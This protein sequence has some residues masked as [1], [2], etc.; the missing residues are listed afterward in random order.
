ME[1]VTRLKQLIESGEQVDAETVKYY[2][3]KIDA[4]LSFEF[5]SNVTEDEVDAFFAHSDYYVNLFVDYMMLYQKFLS[6]Q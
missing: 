5:V 6:N 4:Y 2:I 3:D 1:D